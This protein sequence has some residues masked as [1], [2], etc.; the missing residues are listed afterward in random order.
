MPSNRFVSYDQVPSYVEELKSILEDLEV[1]VS[2]PREGIELL[3]EFYRCDSDIVEQCDDSSG[4]IG[5]F[6]SYDVE[7]LFTSYA[8]Q[9]EEGGCYL[10]SRSAFESA[11]N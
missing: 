10:G 1:G 2:D 6:F 8:K 7:K 5:G 9:L 3:A 11:T 4:A